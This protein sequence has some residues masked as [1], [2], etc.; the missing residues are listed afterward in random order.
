VKLKLIASVLAVGIL[1]CGNAPKLKA[2]QQTQPPAQTD[3]SKSAPPQS[4][5]SDRDIMQKIRKALT[6]DTSLSN[7]VKN[8]KV[9]AQNGKVTLKGTVPSEEDKK[10]VEQKATEVAG[11]GNVTNEL[12]VKPAK[13]TSESMP[14]DPGKQE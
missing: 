14:K 4:A 3:P 12:T 13:K 8:V 5:S 7:D 6:D 11:P 10:N 1:A 2:A 9:S